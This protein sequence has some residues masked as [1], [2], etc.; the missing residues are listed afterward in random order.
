MVIQKKLSTV[1]EV[2]K[3]EISQPEHYKK[4]QPEY[5][6]KSQ[7]KHYKKVMEMK[8]LEIPKG[9]EVPAG[10]KVEITIHPSGP[11]FYGLT[12]LEEKAIIVSVSEQ[13]V[14][15]VEKEWYHKD[16][17][18]MVESREELIRLILWHEIAH[19]RGIRSEH[20]ADAFAEKHLQNKVV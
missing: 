6:K 2:R 10:W 18:V 12:L 19:A 9:V 3:N 15:P 4:S 20:E 14:F 16:E 17:T 8:F 1:F 13:L 5:H 11:I 7:S